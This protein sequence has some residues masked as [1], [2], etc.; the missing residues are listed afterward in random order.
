MTVNHLVGGSSPSLP[1]KKSGMDRDM[2]QNLK[3][4]FDYRI[5]LDTP[6]SA[7]QKDNHRLINSSPVYNGIEVRGG[8][9]RT[10]ASGGDEEFIREMNARPGARATR[11]QLKEFDA[12][13]DFNVRFDDVGHSTFTTRVRMRKGDIF[14]V[15]DSHT[16]IR[17]LYDGQNTEGEFDDVGTT[18]T[19]TSDGSFRLRCN[20]SI[21][22][23]QTHAC[24]WSWN[25]VDNYFWIYR[26]PTN[27]TALSD[28]DVDVGRTISFE[29]FDPPG[30]PSATY[31]DQTFSGL[32]ANRI[33]RT[34][35]GATLP[36]T[37][38]LELI[39][40]DNLIGTVEASDLRAVRTWTGGR[41]G[42]Y[43]RYYIAVGPFEGVTHYLGR[44]SNN[45]FA[46]GNSVRGGT[47]H[48][49]LKDLSH[50]LRD[51]FFNVSAADSGKISWNRTGND[52][53][54]YGISPGTARLFI[55]GNPID[56]TDGIRRAYDITVEEVVPVASIYDVDDLSF[57]VQEIQA[58]ETL[59][60][61]LK[62]WIQPVT[63][64]SP[65]PTITQNPTGTVTTLVRRAYNSNPDQS[66]AYLNVTGIGTSTPKTTKITI[67]DD[68]E[69]K[70]VSLDFR[71][72]P[73][74][75]RSTTET[76]GLR[77][78]S[79]LESGFVLL[80]NV[81]KNIEL[82]EY[83]WWNHEWANGLAFPDDISSATASVVSSHRDIAVASVS[84]TTMRI[85]TGVGNSTA[86]HA[87]VTLTFT[88]T[89]E[90]DTETF[91]VAVPITVLDARGD[92]PP[93]FQ[94]RSGERISPDIVTDAFVANADM[95]DYPVIDDD[96]LAEQHG[97]LDNV[98]MNPD[99]SF[100][101]SETPKSLAGE[102]KLQHINVLGPY[103]EQSDLLEMSNGGA[104]KEV[105]LSFP[106]NIVQ[107]R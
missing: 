102:F 23:G 75:K 11:L 50:P 47:W 28:D 97:V 59:I 57:P 3:Y 60:Y 45:V 89:V 93:R 24:R 34:N 90:G 65:L 19:A 25:G 76:T 29:P 96:V 5:E 73:R 71:V 43:N 74:Q 64:S 69:T 70:G 98:R 6:F 46:Y 72:V 15:F 88:A 107:E 33:V 4:Y 68:G 17:Y 12:V 82:T 85:Q 13:R 63:A 16:A 18:F 100:Q 79:S 30:A 1:A 62:D 92:D 32:V 39:V 22:R 48:V 86:G 104:V 80:G 37:G 10:V 84:G 36:T 21:N 56:R 20:A 44:Q 2:N 38:T 81:D 7:D 54:V 9:Y 26:D 94:N 31:I 105:V 49:V 58:T 99:G 42:L 66:T 61:D 52:V 27:V 95:R 8:D 55:N 67:T 91:S 41:L 106:V 103:S 51:F 14:R 101:I 77:D 83:D 53:V 78:I 35:Q 40:N 87:V